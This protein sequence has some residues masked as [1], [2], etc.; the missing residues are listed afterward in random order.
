MN[1]LLRLIII[2]VFS[3]TISLFSQGLPAFPG[4]E[5]YGAE[6]IGG[7]GGRIIE[8]T[9][10][11]ESG[12]GSLRAAIE[13][14]GP[15]IVIFRVSGYIDLTSPIRLVNPYI[16]IAGQTAPGDGICIRMKPGNSQGIP[17]LIYVPN[18]A[19][20]LHDVIIRYLKFRQGWTLTYKGNGGP[21]PHNI[22]FRKGHDVIV[23]HVS[24]EW[25]RDNLFS[26]SLG[27]GA[28]AADS[29]YNFSIQKCLF[30]ESEEGHSTGMNIQGTSNSEIGTC[31]YT[32]KWIKNISV[33][34]NL[35]TGSDH[36][37]P[38][39]N[40]NVIKVINNVIYNWGDRAGE[41]AHDVKVDYINNY[42]KAGPQTT[43]NIYYQK[44]LH[45]AWGTDCSLASIY[46][47][48]NIMETHFNPP[49]N[50]FD[51]YKMSESGYPPLED[52][53]KRYSPLESAPIPVEILSVENAY[54]AVLADVG[55]N[56]RLDENGVL[57][58]KSDA[59]DTRMI[60]DVINKTG[61]DHAV[62]ESDWTSGA[63]SFPTMTSGT[64]YIDTDNDGMADT[65]EI[66]QF[67]DLT[68]AQYDAT[69]K[70]D[71]D[72]DGYYDLEEFLNASNPKE[73]PTP[74]ELTT[75]DAK[76]VDNKVLLQW[77]TATEVNNYG[78]EIER[79]SIPIG[80]ISDDNNNTSQMGNCEWEKIGFVNGHGNSNSTKRYS[81][82][83]PNPIGGKIKYRLK[84]MD[85]DG[86]YEY[87]EIVMVEIKIPMEFV[88]K[89][90]FPN[91]FNPSTVIKF[92]LSEASKVELE[93]YNILGEKV[94]IL[95]NKNLNAGNHKVV[96]D[97]SNLNSGLYFARI[98][99]GNY[100]K[101]I[102]M[103]FLK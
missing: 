48:G 94:A 55:D 43:D 45:E 54:N 59:V 52:K 46:M 99:S 53:Y 12:A 41:S 6:S 103:L 9:N 44:I 82:V 56:A 3:I 76:V 92:S 77:K 28:E 39:V 73:S 19:D 37:N 60:N 4:A 36:R 95:V 8:V 16:T 88:I 64:P 49:A 61:F 21:R 91:P 90:N 17:G 72:S 25:T 102:K 62:N 98:K 24:S 51:F 74:V 30:G 10:L 20:N 81:F 93:V 58:E 7:R 32:G 11:N 15:R 75:F 86:T 27:S 2:L 65:W 67:G 38:R 83:D 97:A 68:T 13:A 34:K 69:N 89:Q 66:N 22:Y 63:V 26:V 84:Q 85:T 29:I 78:F 70:T 79:S 57:V 80:T 47:S 71:Y 35:F 87:S 18:S 31:F 33:H 101:S 42:Y 40:T 23:D 100:T 50:P 1:V 5:G 96:F 14:S